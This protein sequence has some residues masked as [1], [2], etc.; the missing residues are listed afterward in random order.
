MRNIFLFFLVLWVDPAR[1]AENLVVSAR[2]TN[3]VAFYFGAHPD[4]WQL[5][6]NPNAYY[7]GYE[8]REKCR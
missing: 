1:C 7:D 4:D 3:A 6:M 2:N 8:H 5:F